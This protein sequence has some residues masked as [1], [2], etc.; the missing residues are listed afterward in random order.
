MVPPDATGFRWTATGQDW[1]RRAADAC[2]LDRIFA[3]QGDAEAWL[4]EYWPGLAD[5]GADRVTLISDDV[6]VYTMR[7]DA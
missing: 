6:A 5:A 3:D 1:D 4:A 7:L 2:D